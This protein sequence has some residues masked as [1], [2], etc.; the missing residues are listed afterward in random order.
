MNCDEHY[1]WVACKPG[2]P[3]AYAAHTD[4]PRYRKYLGNFKRREKR[5]GASVIRVTCNE[6]QALLGEYL[7]ASD[8]ASGEPL[9]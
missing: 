1:T 3:G 5:K 2:V 8:A 6:A 9:K 4:D 7:D